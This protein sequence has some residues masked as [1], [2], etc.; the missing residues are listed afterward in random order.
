MFLI[1]FA[2][3]TALMMQSA[4]AE[5]ARAEEARLE[6]CVAKIEVDPENAYEDALA[7][8]FEGNRPGARQCTALAL[9][10]L[11][12]YETGAQRLQMLASS[13]DGGT[14]EQRA[15]YLSQAGQAWI[16]AGAPE[17]AV[18]SFTDA[19]KLAPGTVD[20]LVD[21]ASA[22]MMTEDWDKALSDL[23]LAVANSPSFG[24]A[25]QLRAE[26]HLNKK[27]Y[28]L[29]LRDVEAAMAADPK[30]ID[31]LLVRGRVREAMRVAE[32]DGVPQ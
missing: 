19:L 27:E 15:V 6:A 4:G 10:E 2:A 29:A 3:G 20:L 14:M 18:V 22:Y 7:W 9:I 21:R 16:M 25:H 12:N 17:Q 24:P 11:G 28:G 13:T 31:T 23:D 32:E 30:N 26:V 8:S 1:A 5:M